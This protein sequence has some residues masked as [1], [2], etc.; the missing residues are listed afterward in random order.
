MTKI[1]LSYLVH[2]LFNPQDYLWQC[3]GL[4]LSWKVANDLAKHIEG[5]FIIDYVNLQFKVKQ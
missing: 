4:N 2:R 1:P 5:E 3:N